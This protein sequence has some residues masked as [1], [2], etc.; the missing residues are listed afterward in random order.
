[1]ENALFRNG[2]AHGL[3]GRLPDD[4]FYRRTDIALP[5]PYQLYGIDE[6]VDGGTFQH[7]TMNA[8]IQHPP[9][10]AIFVVNGD[11]DYPDFGEL[12]RDPLAECRTVAI[13]HGDVKQQHV[14]T[15][16]QHRKS[17]VIECC[18]TAADMYGIAMVDGIRQSFV[19]HRVV[20]YDIH[21]YLIF[22]NGNVRLIS[23]PSFS[24]ETIRSVPW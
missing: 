3:A 6:F 8:A 23:V 19:E 2:E 13:G 4:V 14:R 12:S 24:P 1:M 10:N 21:I 22:H 18:E 7:I 5:F 17:T 20:I 15:A 16:F 9:Y 11:S